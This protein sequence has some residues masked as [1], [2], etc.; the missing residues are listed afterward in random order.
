M[1]VLVPP[2]SITPAIVFI[3]PPPGKLDQ[4]WLYRNQFKI[5]MAGLVPAIH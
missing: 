1:R 2:A 5:V 4:F 3:A